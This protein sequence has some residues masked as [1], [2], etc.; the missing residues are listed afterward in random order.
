M[1]MPNIYGHAPFD[2]A[3]WITIEVDEDG[4]PYID[5]YFVPMGVTEFHCFVLRSDANGAAYL[6]EHDFAE[7]AV[8]DEWLEVDSLTD[9]DVAQQVGAII[10]RKVLGRDP[11]AAETWEHKQRTRARESLS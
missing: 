3:Y 7:L 1:S 4:G 9:S 5:A 10:I 6:N 8:D 2:A 11:T